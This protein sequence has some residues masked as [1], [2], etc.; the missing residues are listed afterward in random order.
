LVSL[1]PDFAKAK[2]ALKNIDT[3]FKVGCSDLQD[4]NMVP[5]VNPKF[6]RLFYQAILAYCIRV[7]LLFAII[8][9]F[10]FVGKFWV[11]GAGIVVDSNGYKLARH[12]ILYYFSGNDLQGITCGGR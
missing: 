10:I 11:K 9:A 7:T 3:F 12:S 8:W 4:L 2:S 6:E 1:N 5:R